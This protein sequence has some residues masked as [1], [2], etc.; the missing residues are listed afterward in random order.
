MG[1]VS[2]DYLIPFRKELSKIQTEA[3]THVDSETKRLKDY[4]KDE[5]VQIDKILNEKLTVLSKTEVDNKAKASEIAMKEKT[6][7]W[8]EN[9]QKQINDIIVF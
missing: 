1:E 2:A 7:K 4:L 3:T 8:L 6:L 9:I 5:L